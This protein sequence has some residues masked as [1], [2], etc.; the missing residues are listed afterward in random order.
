MLFLGGM[1]HIYVHMYLYFPNAVTLT[2]HVV[3]QVFFHNLSTI[4]VLLGSALARSNR[5]KRQ[6]L[7]CK[8]RRLVGIFTLIRLS[9]GHI[10]NSLKILE[11]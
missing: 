11:Q 8:S 5:S 4:S 1:G 9:I 2:I 6:V 7:I 10:L 3:S